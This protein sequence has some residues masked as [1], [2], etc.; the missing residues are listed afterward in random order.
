MTRFAGP[1]RLILWPPRGW[2]RMID[3]AHPVRL[4][5]RLRVRAPDDGEDASCQMLSLLPSFPSRSECGPKRTSPPSR[6]STRPRSTRR[7]HRR[8]PRWRPCRSPGRRNVSPYAE[9]LV[10]LNA[11][12]PSRVIQAKLDC[13]PRVLHS[14]PIIHR[15]DGK[16]PEIKPLQCPRIEAGLWDHDLQFVA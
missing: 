15:L 2:G 10:S 13:D 8:L 4:K 16:E 5:P 1:C 6:A 9:A 3:R 11:E 12:A 7:S 14:I